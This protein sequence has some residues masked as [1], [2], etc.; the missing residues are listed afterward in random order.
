MLHSYQALFEIN[1]LL[2]FL[3]EQFFK[4]TF[5]SEHFEANSSYNETNNDPKTVENINIGY[6]NGS[7]GASYNK[8]NMNQCTFLWFL[9]PP[10]ICSISDQNA[11]ALFRSAGGYLRS[12]EVIEGQSRSLKAF[13]IKMKLSKEFDLE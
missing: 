1:V 11:L 9:Q 6:N 12:F 2:I 8:E 5:L 7:S 10:I 4:R 3:G 13:M